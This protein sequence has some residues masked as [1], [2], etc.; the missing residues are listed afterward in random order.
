M[1]RTMETVVSFVSDAAPRSVFGVNAVEA[2]GQEVEEEA[3]DELVRR[4]RHG[5]VA[6]RD[7]DPVQWQAN[8]RKL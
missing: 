6:A 4:Q 8:F 3:A 7:F 5:L 2:V 1:I